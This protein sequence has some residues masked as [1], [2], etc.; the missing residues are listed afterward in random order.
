MAAKAGI[1]K[2]AILI[3]KKEGVDIIE[4]FHIQLSAPGITNPDSVDVPRRPR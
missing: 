2:L 3:L 4:K 1:L